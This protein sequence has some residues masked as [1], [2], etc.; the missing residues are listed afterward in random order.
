MSKNDCIQH[1]TAT[2]N[3]ILLFI[4]ISDEYPI[5]YDIIWALSFNNDI[6]TQ[7]RSQKE[8]I[9]KLSQLVTD[10]PDE[11]LK[12]VISGILWNL[13]S[14][15]GDH[16]SDDLTIVKDKFDIMISYSHKDKELCHRLYSELIKRG[17]RVWIDFDQMHG[18]VMDAMAHAIEH[19][20]MVIICMSEEY[21]RSNYCRAEA[22]Y[23]FQR[24]RKMVPVL[25]QKRYK[26]DGWLLFLIGQL[27]YVDFTKYE[28]EKAMEMLL[29]E[30]EPSEKKMVVDVPTVKIV[31]EAIESKNVLDWT[32]EHVTDLL[33]K[34]DLPQLSE[35]L[36]D[37]NGRSL[38][39]LNHYLKTGDLK[40][41]LKS[42][43]EDAVRR[44]GRSLSYIELARFQSMMSEYK[45]T[46]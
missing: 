19:S 33:I 10:C 15:H 27:L 24:Q 36:K 25:L 31:S 22:Q 44:T 14:H 39:Y 21:R 28:F 23:A 11:Q 32:K 40:S 45:R 18:N 30:L 8:F 42:L 6:A 1:Q 16:D 7:I 46:S 29:K 34:Q 3:K 20:Q 41:I 2:L 35:L 12:K 26:P 4:S 13:Q 5:A 38:S 17:F 37:C 43:N 9:T